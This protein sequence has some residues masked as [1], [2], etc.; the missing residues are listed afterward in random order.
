MTGAKPIVKMQ[1]TFLYAYFDIQKY[2]AFIIAR[3]FIF[4]AAISLM[5]E[6]IFKNVASNYKE[7]INFIFFY[8]FKT[9]FPIQAEVC[10][11]L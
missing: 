3:E 8:R 4:C 2:F 1:R 11:H 10:K 9:K 7:Y 6:F 5:T